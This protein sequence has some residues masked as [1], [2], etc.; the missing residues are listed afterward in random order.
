MQTLLIILGIIFAYLIGSFSSAVWLGRWFHNTDVREFGSKNAG[1]TNT[2]RV[3]GLK[4]GILVFVI[5]V[6][7]GWLAV[8]AGLHLFLPKALSCGSSCVSFCA[9]EDFFVIVLS[10]AVVLGH[11]FPLYT[12][13]KGGKGVATTLGALLAIFPLTVACA[14][15]VWAIIFFSTRYVS[16]ASICAGI[17]FPFFYWYLS[18]EKSLS[19]P[20]FIFSIIIAVFILIMHHKNINRLLHGTEN[21]MSLKRHK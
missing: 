19:V 18:D 2:V 6:L 9:L 8:F 11:V 10:M 13:F 4:T 3:L 20:L 17:V 7:K 15:L 14:L 1:T 16:L 12:G 5:D 21:R